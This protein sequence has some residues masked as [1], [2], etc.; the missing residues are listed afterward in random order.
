MTLTPT[1]VRHVETILPKDYFKVPCPTVVVPKDHSRVV[2]NTAQLVH[3]FIALP[4]RKKF[5]KL[6]RCQTIASRTSPLKPSHV[7]DMCLIRRLHIQAPLRQPS[8]QLALYRQ[9]TL[10]QAILFVMVT[11]TER[12]KLLTSNDYT[13]DSALFTVEPKFSSRME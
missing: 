12:S 4:S 6:L 7:E 5:V 13:I 2:T 10:V 3:Q 9:E 8:Q 11:S 1:P